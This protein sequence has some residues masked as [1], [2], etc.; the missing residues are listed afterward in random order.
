M[1]Q[2]KAYNISYKGLEEGEHEYN[3]VLRNAFFE[4]YEN[5]DIQ[6]ANLNLSVLLN[7]KNTHIEIAFDIKGT[8]AL[9]CDRCLEVFDDEL[10]IHQTIYVKF[11]EAYAEEDE[12]LYVLPESDNDINLA[13][14]INEIVVV[15]LPMRKVHP[16]DEDG[17]P[18]CQ[19]NM[20]D[21]I[22]NISNEGS[23]VVDPRWN[24]LNKLKD[25]AS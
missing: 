21:Y 13:T 16:D 5:E 6:D 20:L 22:D 23:V 8:L 2:L 12:N 10:E 7:K 14:F 18:T 15:A 17:N 4:V 19:N 25:G 9:K 11:G 1:S 24:E 3:Y